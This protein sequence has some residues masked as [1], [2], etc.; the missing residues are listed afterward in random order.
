MSPRI[1][2][3]PM[4]VRD[5]RYHVRELRA[6]EDAHRGLLGRVETAY[7]VAADHLRRSPLHDR[8]AHSSDRIPPKRHRYSPH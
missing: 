2:Q 6:A 1:I 7:R 3:L 4:S 5:R 8:P